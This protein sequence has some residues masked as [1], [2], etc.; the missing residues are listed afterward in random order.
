MALI[1][2]QALNE[3]KRNEQQSDD[4]TPKWKKI[5]VA[6]EF[7]YIYR[8]DASDPTL[9]RTALVS[10]DKSIFLAFRSILVN[11]GLNIY[12][13]M[14]KLRSEFPGR[15]AS[16]ENGAVLIAL[17]ALSFSTSPNSRLGWMLCLL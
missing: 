4:Q 10:E 15:C 12:E 9:N 13:I 11:P 8:K 1:I 3:K 5:R 16:I 14:E 7:P 6:N 17:I 2:Q